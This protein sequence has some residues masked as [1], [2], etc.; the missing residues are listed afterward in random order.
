LTSTLPISL[1][2]SLP[3]LPDA[4]TGLVHVGGARWYNPAT[5]R[6]LQPNTAVGPPTIPQA[7]N[8][9]TAAPLGQ[10]GVGQ[11]AVSAPDPFNNP[12][13]ANP[14]KRAISITGYETTR[15][16]LRNYSR[17][18]LYTV[19]GE[20]IY[21]TVTRAVSRSQLA[22]DVILATG[23]M[24]R[25]FYD[26]LG[27]T[28]ATVANWNPVTLVSPNECILTSANESE[29]MECKSKEAKP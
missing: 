14:F 17:A 21:E 23:R 19:V 8:R 2:G 7:L 18:S 11:A 16:G 6:P 26:E 1:T 25:T 29:E 27:R 20:P 3:D 10:P 15:H 13:T 22:N 28:S 4:A 24:T 5:G 12:F 9:Y